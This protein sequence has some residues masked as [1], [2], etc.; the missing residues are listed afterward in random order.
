MSLRDE[1]RRQEMVSRV[2]STKNDD[3]SVIELGDS[4][5]DVVEEVDAGE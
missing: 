1:R 2:K 5:E 4:D 3:D